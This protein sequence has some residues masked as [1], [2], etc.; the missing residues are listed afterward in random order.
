MR[1][2]DTSGH[3]LFPRSAQAPMGSFCRM[4]AFFLLFNRRVAL[5]RSVYPV[6]TLILSQV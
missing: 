5:L 6:D 2:A 3:R 4:I 1:N